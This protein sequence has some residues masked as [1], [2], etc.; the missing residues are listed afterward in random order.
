[1]IK[2]SPSSLKIFNFNASRI[3]SL[4]RIRSVQSIFESFE[5]DIISIQE[6]DIK[7]SVDVFSNKY[8]VYVNIGDNSSDGIGIVTL[9]RKKLIV[10][11][12]VVGGQGRILGVRLGDLQFWNV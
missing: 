5:P 2:F 9:V 11:D 1:M 3:S 7:G 6:I 10:E 4:R 12:F 8:Q